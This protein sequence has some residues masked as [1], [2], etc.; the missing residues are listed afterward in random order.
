MAFI[1][2]GSRFF[3]MNDKDALNLVYLE[4]TGEVIYH[5]LVIAVTGETFYF[6]DLGFDFPVQTEDGYPLQS[7][8]LDTCTEGG[9]L[10]VTDDEDRAPRVGDMV[11]HMVFDT[12]GF[13][14]SRGGDDDTGFIL[15]V[16]RL[17]IAYVGD[18]PEGVEAERIGVKLHG[19]AHLV[20]QLVGVHTEDLSGVGTHRRIHIDRYMRQRTV[21]IELV[22]H[23]DNLLGSA[24]R[25]RRDQ[26]LPF[27]I[28]AGVLHYA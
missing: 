5:L 4:R 16:K 2:L 15:V 12:S 14:H 18:I 8:L 25:E 10:A 6:G 7:G 20:G 9:R 22:Q 28:D 23:I 24:D 26:E 27:A 21:V 17:R 13:Q 19:V 1:R 11:R 3:A